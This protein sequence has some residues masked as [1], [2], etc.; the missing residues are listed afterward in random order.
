MNENFSPVF[1]SVMKKVEGRGG[2]QSENSKVEI[3]KWEVGRIRK[4]YFL[5]RLSSLKI[6]FLILLFI[7]QI[8]F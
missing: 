5:F 2:G 6:Y 1:G 8:D 4:S 3:E 7:S